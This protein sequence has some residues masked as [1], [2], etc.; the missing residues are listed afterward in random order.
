[1]LS[2][3]EL[4]RR[5]DLL[6][7]RLEAVMD[8]ASR[9]WRPG[10]RRLGFPRQNAEVPPS[11]SIRRKF[12]V[13]QQQAKLNT[14]HQS[15]LDWP[16]CRQLNLYVEAHT[17]G[18]ARLRRMSKSVV[19]SSQILSR[20]WARYAFALL[21][22]A[23]AVLARFALNPVLGDYLPYITFFPVVAFSAWYCGVIPSVLVIIS[24]LIAAQYWF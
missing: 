6:V 9:H 13:A 21:A 23:M 17:S 16:F 10:F 15:L 5:Q 3:M 12:A 14:V 4:L 19:L 20:P 2:A 7:S 22:T 24:S 1:M 11:T 18:S 8:T